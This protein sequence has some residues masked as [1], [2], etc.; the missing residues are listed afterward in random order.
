MYIE[1]A[2]PENFQAIADIYNEY[3]KLGNA[4][5]EENLYTAEGIEAWVKKFNTREKLYVLKTAVYLT[6]SELGKGYGSAMKKHI[7]EACRSMDYKHLVAKIFATNQGSINYNL[8]LGYTIVGTQSKIGFRN[9]QWQD[10]T[11][12]QLL[13]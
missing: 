6:A 9:G 10:V 1:I 8:K 12:M 3:I 5:M 4:T 7:I 13:L 11:I 2:K